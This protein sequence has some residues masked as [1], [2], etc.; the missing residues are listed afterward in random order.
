MKE[1]KYLAVYFRHPP[2]ISCNFSKRKF[3]TIKEPKPPPGVAI[4]VVI[5]FQLY[6]DSFLYNKLFSL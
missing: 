5:P 4:P 2:T 6:I 1:Q 3:G